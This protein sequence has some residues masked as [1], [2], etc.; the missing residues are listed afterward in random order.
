LPEEVALGR[1]VLDDGLDDVIG[2]G[3]RRDIGRCV[4]AAERGV[5]VLGRQLA[6]FDE[7]V[8]AL[9]DRPAGT[10]ERR[11]HGIDE[12]YVEPG[13]RE[14]LGDAVAHGS[15][16]DHADSFDLRHPVIITGLASS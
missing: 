6:L 3:E 13:L 5:A 12:L 15:G 4:E 16:A 2:V 1:G 11:R 14:H 9:R 7:L 8:Q 10:I